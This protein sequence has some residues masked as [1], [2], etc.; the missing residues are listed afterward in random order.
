M[1][2]LCRL[3]EPM[4]RCRVT[5]YSLTLLVIHA[6]NI[7]PMWIVCRVL[8]VGKLGVCWVS[9]VGFLQ[10]TGWGR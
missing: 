1:E 2:A 6:I 8:A 4:A 7:G 9:G 10:K 3:Q 5:G